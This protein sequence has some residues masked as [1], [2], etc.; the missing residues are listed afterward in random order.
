MLLNGSCGQW[1]LCIKRNLL[2]RFG[3][4]HLSTLPA[5]TMSTQ[6]WSNAGPQSATLAQHQTSTGSTPRVCW[7]AFN[8]VNTDKYCYV[9]FVECF[10]M[11]WKYKKL[12]VRDYLFKWTEF[13]CMKYVRSWVVGLPNHPQLRNYMTLSI[14]ILF[15]RQWPSIKYKHVVTYPFIIPSKH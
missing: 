7:A 14:M 11:F 1:R 12:Q 13:F 10:G 4:K 5:N 6:C 3:A 8:P 15:R 2:F 9:S